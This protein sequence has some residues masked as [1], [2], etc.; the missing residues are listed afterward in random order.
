MLVR[1][2]RMYI[3]IYAFSSDV[4]ADK[5]DDVWVLAVILGKKE[6]RGG[7]SGMH[8]HSFFFSVERD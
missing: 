2:A 5:V 7:E 3:I 6:G 8:S 4:S 1:R